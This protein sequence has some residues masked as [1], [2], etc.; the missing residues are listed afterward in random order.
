MQEKVLSF[1]LRTGEE[2]NIQ[3]ER[4]HNTKLLVAQESVRLQVFCV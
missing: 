4:E 3:G 2:G 1:L